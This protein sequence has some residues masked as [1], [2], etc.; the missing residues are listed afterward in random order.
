[1]AVDPTY[2]SS[3]RKQSGYDSPI[4]GWVVGVEDPLQQGRIQIAGDDQDP[5]KVRTEDC[6]WCHIMS[7]MAQSG[8]VGT[9]VGSSSQLRKGMRVLFQ[10]LP[11]GTCY[12]VGAPTTDSGPEAVGGAGQSSGEKTYPTNCVDQITG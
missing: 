1:M 7:P 4:S 5:S 9:S 3:L 2:S 10:R 12:I 6:A 11:D 8:G